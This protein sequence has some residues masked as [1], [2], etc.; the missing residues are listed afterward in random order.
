MSFPLGLALLDM[1]IPIVGAAV[2]A[3][4]GVAGE[5]G[6]GVR[7]L[8]LAYLTG[9]ALLGVVMSLLLMAGLPLDVASIVVVA[10][11]LFVVCAVWAWR[12]PVAPP[13]AGGAFEPS[14]VDTWMSRI[15]AA[16][17][18]VGGAAALVVAIRSEWNPAHDFDALFFYLPR[19]DSIS[20]T[21]HLH[22]ALWREFPHPEYPPLFPVTTASI[23]AFAGFHPTLQ[24]FQQTLLG[25]AFLLG[26]L[27]LLDRVAPRRF[28]VPALALLATTPWFWGSLRSLLPDQTVAYLIAAAALCCVFW[29]L[30]P[31]PAWLAL[32]TLFLAAG[33]LTKLEG[34]LSAVA[35]AVVVVVASVLHFGRRGA[36]AAVY[37]VGPATIVFW[38]IWLHANGLPGTSNVYALSDAVDP[39]YLDHR[40]ARLRFASRAMAYFWSSMLAQ[41]T[42]LARLGTPWQV[43]AWV[44][45][46]ALAVLLVFAARS[47]RT[48]A[49]TVACW[50]VLAFAGLDMIYWI[51][52]IPVA[53]YV[54]ESADRVAETPLM[55]ILTL[56][57]L[58]LALAFRLVP[59]TSTAPSRD[60]LRRPGQ[61][62]PMAEPTPP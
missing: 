36:R 34:M 48:V 56:V 58:L 16:V 30:E 39:S 22:A 61:P 53:V 12:R 59:G 7:L 45:G 40:F 17:L 8:G 18:C 44:L 46:V 3:L 41:S 31:H 27:A 11:V 28:S 52:R 42:P 24:P 6:V 55:V 62:A 43:E 10:A 49:I 47:S 2:L 50:L 60:T 21:H 23:F 4:I 20:T 5:L 1:L 51:G 15:G 25:L 33:T 32:G 19:A 9:W 57:P 13:G 26:M 29:L 35:L 37:L 38:R 14:P 54:A